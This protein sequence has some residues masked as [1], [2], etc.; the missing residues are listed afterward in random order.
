[1][2]PRTASRA[3][4]ACALLVSCEATSYDRRGRPAIP[5]RW[6]F[7]VERC[8]RSIGP[9]AG[10]PRSARRSGSPRSRARAWT[11]RRSGTS[12]P[13]SS[14]APC[15]TTCRPA[16]SPSTPRRCWSRATSTWRSR[17]SHRS[18]WRTST[19]RTTSTTWPTSLAA[20]AGSPPCTR[21]PVAIRVATPAGSS[22]SSPTAPSRNCSWRCERGPE[23]PG[24][25]WAC[26]ASQAGPSSIRRS[27]TSWES[28]PR[29]SPRAPGAGCSSARPQTPREPTP[30]G[31]SC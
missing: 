2:R 1:M 21:R 31:W 16:G 24:A 26:I 23:R 9:W 17:S 3:P 6:H 14:R 25:W 28:W 5:Q 18:G 19:T 29:I 10:M 11:F 15:R 12:A 4:P 20:S 8:R 22:T 30:P 13:M 7:P 27:L